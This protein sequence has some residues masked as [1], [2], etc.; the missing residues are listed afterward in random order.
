[1]FS[2][3]SFLCLIVCVYSNNILKEQSTISS[4]PCKENEH[5]EVNSTSCQLTCDNRYLLSYESICES[6]TGCACN[7]G[8]VRLHRN[9]KCVL[10]DDCPPEEN[11]CGPY[12]EKTDCEITCPPQACESIY[13]TYDCNENKQSKQCRTG[14]NCLEGHLRNAIGMCVPKKFCPTPFYVI[15]SIRDYN[16]PRPRYQEVKLFNREWALTPLV[17]T[18]A[19]NGSTNS[20]SLLPSSSS[21]SANSS[22]GPNP[23]KG[24]NEEWHDCPSCLFERCE[25]VDCPPIPC[26]KIEGS[27]APRCICIQNFFRNGTDVCIPVDE[28]PYYDIE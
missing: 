18:D 1:M 24:V 17:D 22:Q 3:F 7:V 15:R 19:L 20:D 9:G 2:L 10:E 14:C 5:M 25:D 12:E 8:Y 4:G 23:C 6:F 28:C 21:N 26:K 27:C 11:Y 13:M 16:L